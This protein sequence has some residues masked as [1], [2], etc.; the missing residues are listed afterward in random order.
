MTLVELV[1][2]YCILWTKEAN[3]NGFQKAVRK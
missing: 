2:G 1:A 3:S